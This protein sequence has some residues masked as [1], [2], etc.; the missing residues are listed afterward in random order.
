MVWLD[1][2]HYKVRE[3][4]RV[5]TRCVYNILGITTEG[6]K[7]VLGMY[8][9]ESE[10]ANFWLSVLTDLQ[11]RGVEDMLIASIDNLK[12]FAEAI[13]T[14]FPKTDIQSCIVHQ[15]RNSMKYV[16]SKDQ[17]EFMKD[18]KPVYQA[19]SKDLAQ[20]NFEK[21]EE[22][23][24]RKYPVVISSWQRNWDKLT[25]YFKY[26]AEIRKVVYT[27]N[28]IEGYHRQIRKVTKTKGAFTSDMALLKLMYLATKNIEK[29][30]TMPLQNWSITVSQLSIIFG[31]Q[32][33][34]LII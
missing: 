33:L 22:K 25:T 29:K 18:L 15:I 21:L 7:E 16:A 10:G 28:T 13:A 30:W 32:R 31:E 6:R 19:T 14:V 1:A 26:P 11:N 23:W 27:T 34:K 17:K 5:T 8:I 12:G 3:D 4:G 2:M 20:L 9:S 24:S